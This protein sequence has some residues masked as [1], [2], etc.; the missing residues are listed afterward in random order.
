M[1]LGDPVDHLVGL[2]PSGHQGEP[3]NEDDLV[4]LAGEQHLQRA[5]VGDAEAVLD[6]DHVDDI[7][8][9]LELDRVD[10]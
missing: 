1:A 8:R 2:Q 10:V 4:A 7:Q 9:D 5:A 6:A 3:G